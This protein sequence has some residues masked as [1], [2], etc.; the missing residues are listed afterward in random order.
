MSPEQATGDD[1]DGR[2]DIYSL[3]IVLYQMLS[4]GPP[5]DGVSSAKII[6]QQLTATPKDIRDIRSDVTP[7]VAGV[8]GRMID[9]DPAKR[10]Q[11]AGEVS[12]ALVDALPTAAKNRVRPRHRLFSMVMKTLLGL[13]AAGCLAAAAFVAGAAVVFWYV[14]SG[15]PWV[16][17]GAAVPDSLRQSLAAARLPADD[18]IL[19]AYHPGDRGDSIL[20]VV[21]GHR[22]AVRTPHRVRGYARD[23]VAYT[24]DFHWEGGPELRY[25]LLLQGGRRDTVYPDLTPRGAWALAQRVE[26][27]LP[28][29][30]IRGPGP[31][32]ETSAPGAGKVRGGP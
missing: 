12:R 2:S 20:F 10:F 32:V 15:P 18:S 19:L 11:G 4:G 14:L 23:S 8:L 13:G 16:A 28:S 29:D 5:F 17:A 22:V 7:E 6:A 25:V 21:S 9:K 3:G 26:R 1:V 24:F 27:L 30:S 31:R